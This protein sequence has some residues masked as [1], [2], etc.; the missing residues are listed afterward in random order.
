MAWFASRP[1]APEAAK[2]MDLAQ[3]DK[4]LSSLL[5]KKT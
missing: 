2:P 5:G 1:P 4:K 3:A